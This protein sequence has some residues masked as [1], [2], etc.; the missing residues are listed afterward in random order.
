M[1]IRTSI[2][3]RVRIVFLACLCFAGLIFWRVLVIQFKEGDKWKK[4]AEE[5]TLRYMKV[6]A[7]RGNIFSDNGGLL[8][9]SLPFFK[10]S[11]D[12]TIPSDELLKAKIDSFCYNLEKYFG[13]KT[14]NEYKQQIFNYRKNRK[15][16][17]LISKKN[18]NYQEKK[19]IATWP[20]VKEGRLKGGV[21]FEKCDKR[22]LPFGSMAFRTIGFVN[23]ENRGVGLEYSYN[24]LLAGKDGEALFQKIAGNNW[25]PL[26]DDSEVKPEQGYDIQTTIDVNLQDVAEASLRKHLKIHDAD[27]GCVVLMEVKTGEIKAIVNLG[28]DAKGNYFENYNYA[29]GSQGLTDPG[30][31][32]KLASMMA[33]LE[34]TNLNIYDSIHTGNGEVRYAD[35][36]MRD[37][38]PGGYGKLSIVDVFAKSSNVGTSKL[39][40]NT[41]HKNP[42]KFINY[43]KKFHFDRPID[44]QM[45]G[46]AKPYLKTPKDTSW[47]PVTLPWMSIGY[48]IL[49]SPL[50]ILT[51]Y[52]AVANNGKMIKPMIVKKVWRADNIIEEYKTEE[53]VERICS[54]ETREKLL[55]MLEAVVERGTAQ[56][57]KT[58]NYTIAGKTGTAQKIQNKTYTKNYYTSFCGF[59]PSRNPKYS[60]IVVIDNPKGYQQYAADVAAPVFREIADKVY[61]QDFEMH[62]ELET[63]QLKIDNNLLPDF[64]AGNVDDLSYLC[65]KLGISNHSNGF[66]DWVIPSFVNQAIFWKPQKI[67][68]RLIPNVIG[69]SLKDALHILENKG[70]KVKFEGKGKVLEQYPPMGTKFKKGDIIY[71][72]MG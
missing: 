13:G 71:L 40:Y 69:M 6:P 5:V 42:G 45:K 65:N 19:M 61:A 11:M 8:A 50:H 28:K 44:F 59:F 12:P 36:I 33:L 9:T 27:Y 3:L 14:A 39:I 47:S 46:E 23:E 32:F 53:L 17:L 63:E 26:H 62:K 30:S 43:L 31:T 1:N 67:S 70:L 58:E 57:I 2:L 37:A 72:K 16:Y 10:M 20:L 15:R 60:C 34:E 35:R 29:V 48:E 38:K 24:H 41:F 68:Q 7:T 64:Y 18:L 55:T 49:V 22:Y 4:M 54:Q 25:R 51:F 52:N 56:N 21:F 66:D